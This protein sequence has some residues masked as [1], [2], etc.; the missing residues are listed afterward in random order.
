MNIFTPLCV[1][2]NM[3]ML[4]G[5]LYKAGSDEKLN[6]QMSLNPIKCGISAA[7]S[8]LIVRFIE[9]WCQRN[10][11]GVWGVVD[12][13]NLLAVYF[14]TVRDAVLFKMSTEYDYFN[15]KATLTIIN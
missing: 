14:D 8:I 10:C 15:G 9:F 5:P 4:A 12:T 7:R 13:E 2:I 3:N 11:I 6:Y 1:C